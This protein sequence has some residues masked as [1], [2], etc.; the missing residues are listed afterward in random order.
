MNSLNIIGLV[1]FIASFLL[2]AL[3]FKF[4]Q[5]VESGDEYSLTRNQIVLIFLSVLLL[6]V[7]VILLGYGRP[8]I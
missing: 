1:L 5:P 3:S 2:F 7:G 6:S 4:R 8:M